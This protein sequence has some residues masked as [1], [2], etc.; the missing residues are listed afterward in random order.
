MDKV[1]MVPGFIIKLWKMI[2]DP[3]CNDL[4]SWSENGQS[5]IIMD[6]PRFSQE[7]SKYFKHNNLSSFIRQLNMYGF[8]KVATIQNLNDDLHF[9]HPDFVRDNPDGLEAIKRKLPQKIAENVDLKNVIHGIKE[10]EDKHNNVSHSL[11]ELKKENEMLWAELHDLRQKHQQQQLYISRLMKLV[12][13]VMEKHGI[14]TLP[15]KRNPTLMIEGD[16]PTTSTAAPVQIEQ[17]IEQNGDQI[18]ELVPSIMDFSDELN[19]DD[20]FCN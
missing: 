3:D 6:P 13:E 18:D 11:A 7:L 16:Q 1:N 8:R 20:F 14:K 9:Y 15:L 17:H 4:I 12:F 19:I 10:I 5:F 2:N